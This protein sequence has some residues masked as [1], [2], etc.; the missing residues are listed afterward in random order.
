LNALAWSKQYEIASFT[1]SD[2]QRGG[3]TAQQI[4][5]LTEGDMQ[6]IAQRLATI[7]VDEE[8]WSHLPFVSRLVLAEKEQ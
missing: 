7:L 2:L 3:L 6:E 8:F 4:E 1:R 5:S